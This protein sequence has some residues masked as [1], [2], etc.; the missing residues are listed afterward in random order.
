MTSAK[1]QTGID[2]RTSVS[3]ILTDLD[4]ALATR[5]EEQTAHTI[6]RMT[7]MFVARAD[8]YSDEQIGLFDVVIGRLAAGSQLQGRISLSE[9]LADLARAP[10]GVVRQ[11]ALDEIVVARAVLSRSVMLTDHDLIAVASTRGRDHMLA[12]TERAELAEAV[13]DYLV[14]KGDRVVSHAL[15]SNDGARFSSRGMGLLVTRA[16]ADDALQV[17]LGIREDIPPNL[18]TNLGNAARDSARRRLIGK[19]TAQPGSH[20][21]QPADTADTTAE[22]RKTAA[23]I[24]NMLDA[25]G[26]LT[27]ATVAGFA[28]AGKRAEA[29]CALATLARITPDAAEQALFGQ[30]RD[31]SLVIGKAMGWS[32]D[33]VHAMLK[34]RPA[35]EQVPHMIDKIK[36]SFGG[37]APSTAQR[38]LQFM[39]VKDR[40]GAP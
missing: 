5:S 12:I 30:D 27:E 10:R 33:T 26:K 32:W 22:T 1:T 35:T 23:D 14:V 6:A 34:L 21:L 28:A 4:S 19:T 8:D 16:F 39:R 9:R 20:Q 2:G 40:G 13:T 38:V 11:L 24:V 31:A 15:A 25:T 36:D 29:V 3:A 18:M 37:L 17:A 7:D